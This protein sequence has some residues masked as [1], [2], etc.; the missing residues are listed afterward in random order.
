MSSRITNDSHEIRKH[1]REAEAVTDEALIACA[2]L[3]Q[4]MLKA[5]QNPD[6][7]VDAGQ[8]ALLR[9]LEAE[10]QAL[11]MSSNLL[12]VHDELNKAAVEYCGPDTDVITPMTAVAE[13][14]TVESMEVAA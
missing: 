1:I 6:V 11:A 9:L 8:R 10:R 14:E 12:R 4:V 2:K 3:K 7:S 5:R 13:P